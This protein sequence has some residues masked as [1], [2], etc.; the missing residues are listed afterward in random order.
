MPLALTED[1]LSSDFELKELDVQEGTSPRPILLYYQAL[2]GYEQRGLKKMTPGRG[3]R[4]TPCMT[5]KQLSGPEK[6]VI[7]RL[8]SKQTSFSMLSSL[9]H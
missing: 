4:K 7:W 3:I 6:S 8:V 5:Q 2:H 1:V 9:A